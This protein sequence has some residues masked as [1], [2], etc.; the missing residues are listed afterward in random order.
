M[1]QPDVVTQLSATLRRAYQ[2]AWER[3][4]AEKQ[5]IIDDPAQFRRVRR[6]EAVQ[7]RI[8]DD[9]DHLDVLAREWLQSTYPTVYEIGATSVAHDLGVAFQWTQTHLTAISHLANDTFA[10][11]LAAT[12]GVRQSTKRVIRTLAKQGTLSK[13]IEGKTALQA[14]REVRRAIERKGIYAVVYAD[15][16]RHGVAEYSNMVLRTKSAVAYNAG[17]LTTAQSNGVK[18]ME[19]FDGP[20]CGWTSHDDADVANGTVR[21]LEECS[22]DPIAHP[23]CQRSFGPRPDVNTSTAARL[24]T[25][26]ARSAA[27]EIED[28]S[29]RA[30]LERR[31]SRIAAENSGRARRGT[32][33]SRVDRRVQ[34]RSPAQVA[35]DTVRQIHAAGN[36]V[37]AQL[38]QLVS[39]HGGEMV[40]LR[41]RFKT[42]ESLQEKIERDIKTAA[43]KGVEMSPAN[44]G[45]KI[46]DALRFTATTTPSQLIKMQDDVLHALEADGHQ[47]TKLKNT[48]NPREAYNGI[49]VQLRAKDGTPYELQFHTP[50]SFDMKQVVN[51]PFY[52]ESRKTATSDE[53]RAELLDIMRRNNSALVYPRGA[54][55]RYGEP[56]RSRVY[57]QSAS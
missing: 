48:W 38:R 46:A 33:A 8:V 1:P 2:D 51:H 24:A 47:V 17:G 4:V 7:Q 19:V 28:V 54:R 25:D 43:V 10:D 12:E 49:N 44:A 11:L 32:I 29:E 5:A 26:E 30:A 3:V 37:T 56:W 14:S 57:A 15:G 31:S 23:N 45:A 39:G 27:R 40:G 36:A 22:R 6:L 55:A 50:E 9:M 42:P 35:R 21:T 13:M 41:Y 52:E 18:Y 16:S 20:G 34:L 53:R